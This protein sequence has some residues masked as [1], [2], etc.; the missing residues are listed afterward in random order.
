MSLTLIT[1]TSA[2]IGWALNENLKRIRRELLN[3]VPLNGRAV[4]HGDLDFQKT[5]TISSIQSG[6]LPEAAYS[7]DG[8]IAVKNA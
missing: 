6:N 2:N 5:Y 8:T 3:K 7:V 1:I 4:M